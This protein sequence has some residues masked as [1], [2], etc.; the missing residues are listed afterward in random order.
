MK[1]VRQGLTEQLT[2]RASDVIVTS[3]RVAEGTEEAEFLTTE[4]AEGAETFLKK[5]ED[6]EGAERRQKLRLSVM[7]RIA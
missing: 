5:A 2:A 3:S 4:G 6:A 1:R 7:W